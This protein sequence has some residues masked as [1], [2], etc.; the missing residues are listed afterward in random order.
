V[1]LLSLAQSRFIKANRELKKS[2]AS[3]S[4]LFFSLRKKFFHQVDDL[5]RQSI[6][7]EKQK[8]SILTMFVANKPHWQPKFLF[9]KKQ[10]R[11]NEIPPMSTQNNRPCHRTSLRP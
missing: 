10:K 2:K 11:A 7:H 4:F 1:P 6:A 9:L 8:A 3:F 5:N